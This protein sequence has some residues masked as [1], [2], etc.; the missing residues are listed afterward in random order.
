[1]PSV[2][3]Y[4]LP[5]HCELDALRGGCA[6]ILDILR[7]STTIIQALASGVK[8]VIPCG[9]VAEAE[10][11]ATKIREAGGQPILGGERGGVRLPGFDLGNSPA[12]YTPERMAGRTLVFTTT[13]GTR[14]LLRARQARQ[15]F[16]GGFVNL[17]AVVN[18]LAADGGDVHILCA[19]TDGEI[20]LEDVLCAGAIVAGLPAST[21]YGNDEAYLAAATW[22]KHGRD[23]AH[24]AQA[25]R[26]SRGGRNLIELGLE[27]D[28]PLAAARD[29]RTIVPSW[30]VSTG[31]ITRCT[32]QMRQR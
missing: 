10:G 26:N 2:R 21:S 7:A 9:E 1:M 5:S 29:A 16:V 24:I 11:V 32:S 14:A 13:N 28:I 25:L 15:I 27:S 12:E 3:V 6:V 17:Q 30:D 23:P 8:A 18:N 31:L 22:D 20:S 4:L 19:G